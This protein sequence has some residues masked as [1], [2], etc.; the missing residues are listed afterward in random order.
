MPPVQACC[1]RRVG[2]M[3]G[4]RWRPHGAGSAPPSPA[5]RSGALAA[6]ARS[7]API[8]RRSLHLW[9]LHCA[10]LARQPTPPD[11]K[12]ARSPQVAPGEQRW[13]RAALHHWCSALPARG[14]GDR[15]LALPPGSAT[16]ALHDR[17]P[18]GAQRHQILHQI[19]RLVMLVRHLVAL[20]L[21][22]G[23]QLR[24]PLLRDLSQLLDARLDAAN[25]PVDGGD[26]GQALLLLRLQR[27]QKGVIGRA[28]PMQVGADGPGAPSRGSLSGAAGSG[29]GGRAAQSR[30]TACKGV[31]PVAGVGGEGA[32][33][34][35]TQSPSLSRWDPT[36]QVHRCSPFDDRGPAAIAALTRPR[37]VGTWQDGT[38]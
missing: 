13:E 21:D 24:L 7:R 26:G 10:P 37:P 1:E 12:A 38:F 9:R 29:K 33:I 6:V 14:T 8:A 2:H 32:A 25:L 16:R 5:W 20:G 19:L 22:F 4:A 15:A 3:T 11:P 28:A 36:A 35:G 34:A 30:G 31:L 27:L 18:G 17:L 23:R